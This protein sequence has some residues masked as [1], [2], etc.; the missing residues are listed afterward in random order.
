M[1]KTGIRTHFLVFPTNRF[2]F[3]RGHTFSMERA[4]HA[5]RKILFWLVALV[6]V[7][8]LPSFAQQRSRPAQSNEAENLITAGETAFAAGRFDEALR[9]YN[10][11]VAL[12][13]KTPKILAQANLKIGKVYLAQKKFDAARLSFQRAIDL[14]PRSAEAYND[15]GEAFGELKQFTRALESFARAIALDPK[16]L[17]ARYNMAVTYAR[18]GK[19][20]YAEF[21][22]RKLIQVGPQYAL[23]FDGL[24]VTLAR[25][26]RAKEAISYHERA[27]SLEPQDPSYRYNLA[28]SYLILGDTAKAVE[29][30]EKLRRLDT[31]MADRLASAIIK[32]RL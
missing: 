32:H 24:A 2:D 5:R 9:L 12:S 13:L 22:F 25:M 29:Q 31:E 14:N 27:I 8:S 15:L 4:G 1:E 19:P 28:L 26:G 18:L 23:G 3:K 30:Q 16:L 7:T 10:R 17:R 20:Q 21:V 6:L 11:A